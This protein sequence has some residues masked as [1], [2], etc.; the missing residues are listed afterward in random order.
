MNYLTDIILLC[1]I[2]VIMLCKQ[3]NSFSI[4]FSGNPL[5]VCRVTMCIVGPKE[6]YQFDINEIHPSTKKLAIKHWENFDKF[7][8]HHIVSKH[9]Y[10]AFETASIFVDKFYENTNRPKEVIL[11]SGCGRGMSSIQ[12]ANSFPE[13]P[14]IGVDQS[15]VRLSHNKFYENSLDNYDESLSD[16]NSNDYEGSNDDEELLRYSKLEN[17]LLLRAELVDF[18]VLVAKYSDWI[19][20]RHYI[21]YPNPYPKSKHLSRRWHGMLSLLFNSFPLNLILIG[22]PVFPIIIMLGGT[23]EIRS[24]WIVYCEEMKL[25]LES[26]SS[27]KCNISLKKL[28]SENPMTHFERKYRL[29]EIDLYQLIVDFEKNADIRHKDLFLQLDRVKN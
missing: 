27:I 15:I 12:L 1:F 13:F 14:V 11:D 22:H 8:K 6:L 23:L 25:A 16:N 18:F 7:Y 4:R 9:T 29:A 20:A 24:N 5:H 10:D 19:I 21:L 2:F 28:S 26:I 3:F 17:L